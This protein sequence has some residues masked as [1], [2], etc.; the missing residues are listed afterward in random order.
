VALL[1]ARAAAMTTQSA[2][3]Q[4]ERADVVL[5]TARSSFPA[6]NGWKLTI[7]LEE[8]SIPYK[9]SLLD[10]DKREH[11]QEWFLAINPN[12]RI[13]AIV[14]YTATPPVS[15]FES[16]AIMLYLAEKYQRFIGDPSHPTQRW[17]VIQWLF[18]QCSGVG[19]IQGQAH[20]F[21]RYVPERLPYAIERFQGETRRLYEVVNERLGKCTYIAGDHYCIADMALYP[22][23]EYHQWAGVSVADLPHLQRW[24]EEVR[25]RPA[26][27]RARKLSMEGKDIDTLLAK[28]ADIQKVVEGSTLDKTDKTKTY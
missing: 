17:D 22:W 25:Q 9:I 23:L 13:P 1:R 20:A 28:A 14:D 11:K 4:T 24:L 2:A 12:G 5:Y 18:F 3:H 7:L 16:G 10:L 26:V 19:P 15:V 27:E 6:F 8:L 21:L